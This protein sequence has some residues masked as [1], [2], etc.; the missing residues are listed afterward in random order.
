MASSTS[1]GDVTSGSLDTTVTSVAH[2]DRL[3]QQINELQSDLGRTLSVAQSLRTENDSL[4]AGYEKVKQELT[5][6]KGKH[7]A[8]RQ[9][10]MDEAELELEQKH[11][12]LVSEWK[13]QLES[14]E[15]EFLAMQEQMAPPRDLDVLRVRIQEELE[16]PHQKRVAELE[17]AIEKHR[18]LYFT[19]KR[20]AELLKAEFEQSSADH[21]AD[22]EATAAAH[23]AQVKTLKRRIADLEER[24]D[25]DGR[26]A[27]DA[28]RAA[29]AA[30]DDAAVARA[31]LAAEATEMREQR[32]AARTALESAQAEAQASSL[33]LKSEAGAAAND[34]A[35][36][37]RRALTAEEEAA[38]LRGALATANTQ[39]ASLERS[40]TRL[41]AKV[42][43][44]EARVRD[45]AATAA[46]KAD[47]AAAAWARERED[48][49]ATARAAS[50]RAEGAEDRVR[51]LEGDA[52][53]SA[54]EHAA[55]M[56]ALQRRVEA[57]EAGQKQAPP[58]GAGQL[59]A[60]G[61]QAQIDA[62][63]G[64]V[65]MVSTSEIRE[66]REEATTAHAAA[67]SSAEE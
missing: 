19:S 28:L 30:A 22:A 7:D 39:L 66:L 31:R 2:Y 5:R 8:V 11:E 41:E 26:T 9:Q 18:A 61:S 14:K 59:I 44:L 52:L 54:R 45:D 49:Q 23:T 40:N 4:R 12:E 24:L 58:A 60:L 65:V 57:A 42:S 36:A 29:Q 64:P 13:Q 33:R 10:Y 50:R 25:G 51:Q 37:D 34:A 20:E 56:S 43:T 62:A 48:L 27:A 53:A 55:S 15:Q 16:V 6:M 38:R 46:D 35:A 1:G 21:A 32:D 17:A 47:A 3:L 67:T 63:T